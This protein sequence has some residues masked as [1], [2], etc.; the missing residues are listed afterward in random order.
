MASTT[1]VT[2][3]F[4]GPAAARTVELLGSW[5]NFDKPYQMKRDR[6]RG[7]AIW[8]GC[9]TFEDII[10]DGDLDNLGGRRNGALKMGGTYWY[11]Y[12][13]D[14]DDEYHNP[15]EP[16]TTICPL[17]PGQRLN[18]LEVPTESRSR[19][20]SASSTSSSTF[21]RNPD[22]KY[23]TPV[24]P[25]PLPSLRLGDL[26][27]Q[28]YSVSMHSIGAPRSATYPSTMRTLSPGFERQAQSASSSPRLSSNAMFSD[29]RGL[30]D[31]FIGSK[32]SD[33]AGRGCSAHPRNVR[34]LRI[35]APTLISS[36][37]EEL[38][39]VPL[40]SQRI[41]QTASSLPPPV[42]TKMKEFSPLGSHPVDPLKDFDFGFSKPTSTVEERPSK[43]PRSHVTSNAPSEFKLNAGRA[44]ANSADTRRTK[45][46]VFPNEPWISSPILEK[47]MDADKISIPV[48]QK[49]STSVAPISTTTTDER[50]SSRRGGGKS[51]A[52]RKLPLLDKE[53]PEL[54]RYLVPAPLFACHGS[55]TQN[56]QDEEPDPQTNTNTDHSSH[57]SVWSTESITCSSPTLDEDTVHS[58]TFSSLTNSSSDIET[59]QRFSDHFLHGDQISS[60]AYK[61]EGENKENE[62]HGDNNSPTHSPGSIAYP[63]LQLNVPSFGPDLFQLDIHH[64]DAAPRRQVVCFGR[65]SDGFKGYSLPDDATASQTTITK[66]SPSIPEPSIT[67]EPITSVSQLE[68]LMSEFGYLGEAVL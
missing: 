17:L 19:S 27:Q 6:R 58:P 54:P 52:L 55:P 62:E 59:P 24:P 14:D 45:Q 64:S 34:E 44:R 48:L 46:Y 1:L 12:K 66:L 43:R 13:V 56:D 22:D 57:F 38:D 7:S 35:G 18:I 29:I 9:Y 30:K 16:S 61:S 25:K 20:N 26:C 15:S 65:I 28:P 60:N 10:C 40:P 53:L 5:D 67:S 33:S 37:A 11:Y 51:P 41:P 3:F 23:L 49:P 4:D 8:S 36:T 63:L 21:T 42:T 31:K 32:R 39:L 68:K 47:S 2:F 50:P